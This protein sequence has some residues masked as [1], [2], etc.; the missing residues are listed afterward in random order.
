M[1]KLTS[2]ILLSS[3]VLLSAQA[4]ASTIFD[5]EELTDTNIGQVSGILANGTAFGTANTGENAFDYFNWTK[6]SITLTAS[7]YYTG[8]GT[9]SDSYAGAY[10]QGDSIKSWAY[11]DQGNAGLGVCSLGLKTDS[12]G[13]NQCNPGNDDNVTENEVLA[14]SF[15]KLVSIDFSQ[16]VFRN[17]SHHVH[18]P[19]IDISLDNGSTWGLMDLNATLSSNSFLFRT[20]PIHDTNQFYID[21]L[22][23]S[24]VTTTNKVSEPGSLALLGLGLIGLGFSRK[25]TKV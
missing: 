23:I 11:L 7:A 3:A 13:D 8:P 6:D 15:D 10:N 21:A 1:N 2:S 14:I 19:S 22:A 5:F 20:N 24:T 17:G 12:K 9:Y 4:N 18:T 16:T 25:K